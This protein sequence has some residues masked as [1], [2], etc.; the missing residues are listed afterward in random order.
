MD[1]IIES[2]LKRGNDYYRTFYLYAVGG[3]T[4]SNHFLSI[5]DNDFFVQNRFF[6]ENQGFLG[7][8]YQNGLIYPC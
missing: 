6:P 8:F 2:T 1:L 4:T 5:T 7:I 3:D